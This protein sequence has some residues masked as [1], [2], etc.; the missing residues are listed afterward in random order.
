MLPSRGGN[1]SDEN[2]RMCTQTHPKLKRSQCLLCYRSGSVLNAV[3][4]AYLLNLCSDI[5]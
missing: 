4:N 3:E 1:G 5:W 2:A